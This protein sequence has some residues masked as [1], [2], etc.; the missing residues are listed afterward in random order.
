MERFIDAPIDFP[1][2]E[3]PA[4]VANGFFVC[5]DSE[6]KPE[7]SCEFRCNPGYAISGL[8]NNTCKHNLNAQVNEGNDP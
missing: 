3:D 5:E 8:T 7:S 2:C 1:D 4:A 6:K